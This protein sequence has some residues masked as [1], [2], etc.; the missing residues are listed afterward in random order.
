[1]ECVKVN[2]I[3]LCQN[4]IFEVNIVGFAIPYISCFYTKLQLML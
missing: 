2:E 1:M 3:A 4:K